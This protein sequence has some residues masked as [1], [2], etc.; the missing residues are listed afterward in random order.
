MA[1]KL[2]VLWFGARGEADDRAATRPVYAARL[3]TALTEQGHLT[4]QMAAG[5]YVTAGVS[6]A[7]VASGETPVEVASFKRLMTRKNAQQERRPQQSPA[8]EA[9]RRTHQLASLRNTPVVGPQPDDHDLPC[10][11]NDT[12]NQHPGPTARP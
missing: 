11:P 3:V 4:E 12:P 2:G 8:K 6:T 7:V 10:P 9:K 1:E 5:Q